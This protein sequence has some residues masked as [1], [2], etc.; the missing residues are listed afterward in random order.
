M[1]LHCFSRE[2]KCFLFVAFFGFGFEFGGRVV[3]DSMDCD[4][5]PITS[6]LPT[7]DVALRHGV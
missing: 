5:T 3:K 2:I 1:C 7:K 4:E 6:V